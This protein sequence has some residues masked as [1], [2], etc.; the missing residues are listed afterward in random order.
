VRLFIIFTIFAGAFVLLCVGLISVIVGKNL[1]ALIPWWATSGYIVGIALL[2]LK[3]FY[4][5]INA[6]WR[7]LKADPGS[8]VEPDSWPQSGG[9]FGTINADDIT[10]ARSFAGENGLSICRFRRFIKERSWIEIPW[11]RIESVEIYEPDFAVEDTAG[12]RQKRKIISSLLTAQVK[13]KRDRSSMTLV[14]PWNEEFAKYAPPSVKI[15]KDWE[16]PYSVL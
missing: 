6:L 16:W 12:S 10:T 4:A 3:D 7:A 14:M 15:V 8:P 2:S 1:L 11:S 5:P 9:I 13:L